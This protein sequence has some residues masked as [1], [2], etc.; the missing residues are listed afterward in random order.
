MRTQ[1]SLYVKENVNKLDYIEISIF[2]SKYVKSKNT[3]A[4]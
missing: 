1:K 4:Y 2:S 3:S